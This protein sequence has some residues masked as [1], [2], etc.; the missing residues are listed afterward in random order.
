M[1]ILHVALLF[2]L[3]MVAHVEVGE[4]SGLGSVQH[5]S[6]KRCEAEYAEVSTNCGGGSYVGVLKKGILLVW[7]HIR[8]PSFV[9]SLMWGLFWKVIALESGKQHMLDPCHSRTIAWTC[10]W[11][12]VGSSS[13]RL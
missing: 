11:Y 10:A 2:L 13:P 5:C 3:L 4:I 12:N 9:E 6:A 7:V 1:P 8:C